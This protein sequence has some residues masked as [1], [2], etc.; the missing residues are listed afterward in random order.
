MSACHT[1]VDTS[2][3][4]PH[5][6]ASGQAGGDAPAGG[7]RSRGARKRASRDTPRDWDQCH[8]PQTRVGLSPSPDR[9]GRSSPPWDELP[10]A[11]HDRLCC[12]ASFSKPMVSSARFL[13][14]P[15]TVR[16][17]CSSRVPHARQAAL[18]ALSSPSEASRTLNVRTCAVHIFLDLFCVTPPPAPDAVE[19]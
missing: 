19:H 10:P 17:A 7:S 12:V 3:R 9:C 16:D 2:W 11:Q 4:W 15:V 8:Q 5:M 6:C 13:A 18:V 1:P 14:A